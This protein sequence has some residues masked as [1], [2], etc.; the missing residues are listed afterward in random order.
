MAKTATRVEL[1][2]TGF[3]LA[4]TEVFVT[5]KDSSPNSPLIPCEVESV[6]AD[7]WIICTAD[8]KTTTEGPLMAQL[9]SYGATTDW[10][11]IATILPGMTLFFS[12]SFF[13]FL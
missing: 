5:L 4:L 12:S 3:D 7:M 11:Q 2:G 9:L 8:L 13:S 1:I 6:M 10:V